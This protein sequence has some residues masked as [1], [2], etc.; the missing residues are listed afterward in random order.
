M[1]RPQLE[2]IEVDGVEYLMHPETPALLDSCRSRAKGTFLLP[3]FD[4]YML[5]YQDRGA[6][7]PAEFAQRV[8][9]GNNGMFQPTRHRRRQ[10]HRH[11]EKKPVA[12]P[13]RPWS[14]HRSP[15]SRARFKTNFHGC[16][17]TFR[18]RSRTRD[19]LG[20]LGPARRITPDNVNRYSAPNGA[21][22]RL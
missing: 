4:E 2:R 8:V 6:A 10:G 9:P 18:R 11:L 1:A 22:R 7:L 3:G 19:L 16:T 12:A 5:G 15:H 13:S 21:R 17:T 20:H 14:P